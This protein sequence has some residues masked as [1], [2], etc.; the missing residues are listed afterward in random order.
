MN[1][2]FFSFFFLRTQVD[3][4]KQ[5]AFKFLSVLEG[6]RDW[7]VCSPDISA[8]V[9]F[10]RQKIVEMSVD[11]YEEWFQQQFPTVRPRLHNTEANAK[12]KA[13]T[14]NL[15]T[16]HVKAHSLSHSLLLSVNGL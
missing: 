4:G 3:S 12:A 1:F 13:N 15:L 16:M 14:L 11:E 8:A 5:S 2:D 6:L 7:E 10:C 9:E